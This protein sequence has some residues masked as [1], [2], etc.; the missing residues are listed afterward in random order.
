MANTSGKL[1]NN[2]LVL[3]LI[4][5]LM[6]AVFFGSLTFLKNLYQTET[7]WVVSEEAGVIPA[8]TMIDETML[9]PIETAK[10]T[11]PPNA[12]TLAEINSAPHFTVYPVGPGEIITPTNTL[13]NFSDISTGVPDSY[14]ITSFSVPADDAVG[15]RISR[16]IYFDMMVTSPDGSFY[17]FTNMLVLDTSI[18]LSGASN[19]NAVN[20]AESKAGQTSIYYVALSPSDAAILQTV[21][22]KYAGAIKLVLAPR[23]NEYQAPNLEAYEGVFTF[24]PQNYDLKNYGQGQDN[25]FRDVE[26]D[27]FGRPKALDDQ[28]NR[29]YEERCGNSQ[30]SA[31]IDCSDTIDNN[32]GV[33]GSGAGGRD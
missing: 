30:A 2:K 24:D 29:L 23:E 17:P 28:G 13:N 9:R 16:G 33:E 11:S 25:T 21:M 18:A 32:A 27:D 19:S 15:G 12:L 22:K 1:R 14:V 20:T 4:L 5:V 8:R 10:D 6:A 31:G 3:L 7:Y 26:R